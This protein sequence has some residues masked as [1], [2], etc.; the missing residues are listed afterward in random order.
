MARLKTL[1]ADFL[2]GNGFYRFKID[3]LRAAV[4][5]RCR[6]EAVMVAKIEHSASRGR[7]DRTRSLA[8]PSSRGTRVRD[9]P[10][11]I[12]IAARLAATC[13]EITVVM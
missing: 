3:D 6:S 13:T 10:P 2:N 7:R 5:A 9:L 11:R 12:D 8:F 4:V 1:E